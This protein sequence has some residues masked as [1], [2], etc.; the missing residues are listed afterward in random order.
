MEIK[1]RGFNKRTK[2]WLY[3]NLINVKSKVYILDVSK[4]K[5]ITNSYNQTYL[6][7][8]DT[9]ILVDKNSVGQYTNLKDR[10]GKE[11]YVGDVLKYF[12]NKTNNNIYSKVIEVTGGFG[13]LNKYWW[14][15]EQYPYMHQELSDL[16]TASYVNENYEVV[17]NIYEGYKNEKDN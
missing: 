16:Q 6:Q 4:N 9:N 3:G 10:N 14:E 11:I 13:L 5:K 12:N 7:N 17:G 1:F 2:K 15:D 8:A